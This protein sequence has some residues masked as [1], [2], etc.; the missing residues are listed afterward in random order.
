MFDLSGKAALVAGGAG[1]LS[2]PSCRGLAQH[3]A[4]IMVADINAHGVDQ[5][6][7]DLNGRFS[8]AKVGG[9]I[10]DIGD[11]QSIRSAVARTLETFGRLDILINA[12]YLSIGKLVEELSGAEF[13][14]SLHVNVT[15][16]FLLAREASQYMKDGGSIIF[17]SSM[18]GEIAPDPR[19]Y[20]A[21][22][23]PNPIEYGVAKA[24]LEQMVRYLAVCWAP[25]NIRVNGIAPGAFPHPQQQEHDADWM[26]ILASRAPLGRVGRQ[27]EV[28]GAVLFL[29]SD[30]ASYVTGHILNVDGGWTAW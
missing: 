29:A 26:R 27:D 11:E 22:I 15:S 16:S 4:N 3:G 12:T 25:R 19:N 18:Y 28:A 6:V 17:Y 2:I 30:E 13:D 5:M 9:A 8:T 7:A 1:Y 10:L 14:A 21:P 24:G 20:P 23:K